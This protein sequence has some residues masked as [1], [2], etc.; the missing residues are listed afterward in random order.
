MAHQF[1]IF[2]QRGKVRSRPVAG[3]GLP[4]LGGMPSLPVGGR[5]F[6]NIVSLEPVSEEAVAVQAQKI[7]GRDYA[8]IGAKTIELENDMTVLTIRS[9]KMYFMSYEE[10]VGT[11]KGFGGLAVCEVTQPQYSGIGSVNDTRMGVLEDDELCATCRKTNMDCP[12]HLAYINLRRWYINPLAVQQTIWMLQ[13]VCNSCGRLLLSDDDVKAEG[14]T[15]YRDTTRLQ[16]MAEITT[17]GQGMRCRH[18]LNPEG[19]VVRTPCVA[20]PEFETKLKN[21]YKVWYKRKDKSGNEVENEMSIKKIDDIFSHIPPIDLHLMG[22]NIAPLIPSQDPTVVRPNEHVRHAHP[23]NFIMKALPVC[24][25]NSRPYVI[26]EGEV[27]HDHL[28]F[29]YVCVTSWNNSLLEAMSSRKVDADNKR[30]TAERQLWFHISH[31]MDNGDHKYTRGQD[32]P[33]Q[34]VKERLTSKE[35]YIRGMGM[36]KRVDFCLRS[37]VTPAMV[38]FE[39]SACPERSRRVLT[40]PEIV[41]KRN[42][43]RLLKEYKESRVTYIIAGSGTMKGKRIRINDNTRKEYTPH[44]GDTLERW[45]KDGDELAANRAP[46]L[47]K[48]GFMGHRAKY[49]PWETIGLH[50]SHTSPYNADHDGDEMNIHKLQTMSARA[51]ARHIFSVED[52]IMNAQSNRPI[53]GLV[54]NDIS[55]SYMMSANIPSKGVKDLTDEEWKTALSAKATIKGVIIRADLRAELKEEEKKLKAE[56]KKLKAE[57]L[58]ER[59]KKLN[60]EKLDTRPT[61]M[62]DEEDW[63][64]ALAYLDDRR[65]ID[66]DPQGRWQSLE[67]RLARHHI[68]QR[69]GYALFSA[70]LPPDFYYNGGDV[71]IRDGVLRK[72]TLT[73]KHVGPS[74]GAIIHEMWKMYSKKVVSR[75]LTEAHFICGWFLSIWGLTVGY[76]DCVAPNARQVAHIINKEINNTRLQIEGLGPDTPDMSLIEREYREK[77]VQ[78]FLN[79]LSKIGNDISVE[80]LAKDNPLNIMGNSGAKGESRNTAQITGLLGQQFIKGERPKRTLGGGSRCLICFEKGS[81]DIEALGFI[82]ENFFVGTKPSGMFFHM[83]ASRIGLVDTAVKTSESG[84]LHHKLNKTFEDVSLHYSGSLSN[85][86]GVIFSYVFSDGFDAGELITPLKDFRSTGPVCNFIDLHTIVGKLNHE[87]GFDNVT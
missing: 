84:F 27:K 82:Y 14:L 77:Q 41:T 66:A 74:Q 47:H 6:K 39:E 8:K 72:G 15:S 40:T 1:D 13:I 11:Q 85:A 73:K 38:R 63:T 69:S 24:P 58:K 18:H 61:V 44:I 20:N 7:T 30:E 50:S 9:S 26:T 70:C 81:T 36:G 55:A 59:E 19:G 76:K 83:C 60:A 2:Q 45:A 86:S 16:K 42:F 33:I 54:Y 23:R 56:R 80:A 35:G 68:P 28:T 25:P 51:E 5:E 37:V 48:Q 3:L 34:S 64:E 17:K 52:N 46:T 78:G 49:W 57:E 12:G 21:G 4:S 75:F 79:N 32:E 31:M 67:E 87:A 71:E 10:L 62:L 53:M 65:S 22:F 43:P 29:A